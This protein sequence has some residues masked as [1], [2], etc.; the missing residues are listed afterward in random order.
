MKHT[1]MMIFF[2]ALLQPVCAQ[3]DSSGYREVSFGIKAGMSAGSLYG[4]DLHLLSTGSY[5]KPLPGIFAGITVQTRL[6]KYFGIQSELSVGQ[7][8]LMLHLLDSN[9]QQVYN[10]RFKSTY[11]LI[12]PITPTVYFHGFRLSAGPYVSG[13]LHSSI[14][15]KGANGQITADKNI[16][17]TATASGGF[18]YKLDAGI[19]VQLRYEC[20]N[21][22]NI[23]A[24]YS[25]G[26]ILVIED[27][28]MQHQ[29]KIYN[30]QFNLFLGYQ[31][32]KK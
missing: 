3:Q 11:L 12:A 10:S 27:P 22:W 32:R 13:L 20:K 29:W 2:L 24:G 7:S 30:Q 8:P 9:S 6:G 26:F 1:L 14:E 17:G 19:A 5:V 18:R 28:R 4:K 25:R 16:F 21:G 15:R 23:G 31:W